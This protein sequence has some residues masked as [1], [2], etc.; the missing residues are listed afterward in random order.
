MAS[1]FYF[2]LLLR[3]FQSTVISVAKFL[4]TC[5]VSEISKDKKDKVI[6]L[7]KQL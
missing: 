6:F 3:T 4:M 2:G 1:Y 7:K 5:L